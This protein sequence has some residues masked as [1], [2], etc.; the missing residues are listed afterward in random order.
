MLRSLAVAALGFSCLASAAASAQDKALQPLAINYTLPNAIWWNIDVAIDKGF[1]KDEGFAPEAIPFQNSP[2]AVQLLISKSV[3]AAV[4]Q[5]EALLDA[6]THGAGLAAIAQTESRPDWF[7]VVAP[8]VKDWADIKGKNI[9]FSSLKVNE[10]WLT[11]KLLS[12]HG[13]AKTDWTALQVGVTPL[14]VAALTKG[15]I[16]AAPLF[17]PGAQQAMKDGLKPI[18]RYDELGD[19]PPSL[20][21]VSKSWATENRNGIRFGHAIQHAH[22]WLSDPANR[23]EAQNILAKYTKVTPDVA[24]QVYEIL[25]IT[26][27]IYSHDGAVDLKGLKN[28]LQLVAEAGQMPAD[29]LPPPESLVLP[30]ADGGL[31]H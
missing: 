7:L 6:N 29:K 9:G 15:S 17:Q 21:V 5:P 1:L 30:A 10:V 13:L 16:A 8:A 25:F 31:V 12:Q 20:I 14:K 22:A 26:D 27:K 3:Q 23:N 11:E 4:V 18:A 2:Q 28:A 24:Q 19:S